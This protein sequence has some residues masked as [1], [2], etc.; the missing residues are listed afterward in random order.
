MN[1]F[2]KRLS[3]IFVSGLLILTTA[4]SCSLPGINLFNNQAK[5]NYKYGVLKF[6]PNITVDKFA[7]VNHIKT[8]DSIADN[9][10]SSFQTFNFKAYNSDRLFVLTQ[11]KGLFVS[12]NGGQFWERKYVFPINGQKQ[13]DIN[14]QIARNDQFK[15]LSY[16]IQDE[17]NFL[18]AGID[19]DSKGK[20]FKTNNGGSSFT[21]VY[22][23]FGKDI[24]VEIIKIDPQNKNIVYAVLTGGAVI[25]SNDFGNNWQKIQSF[26]ETPII[27]D[28]LNNN[29]IYALFGKSGLK[30]SN[31]GGNNW[32]DQ[33]LTK[34]S[35]NIGEN[36]NRDALI[37]NPLD[38]NETFGEFKTI[39]FIQSNLNP[40][41]IPGFLIADR[42][43]WISGDIKTQKFVKIPLPVQNE[44]NELNDIAYSPSLGQNKIYIA[45]ND[46][47]LISEDTG[48]SWNVN[49]N[50]KLN[51][52]LTIGDIQSINF[53]PNNDKIMYLTIKSLNQTKRGFF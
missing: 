38:R 43:L 3:L 44:Q 35:S 17:N 51:K 28:F 10:L 26:R 24:S 34:S 53:D 48:K 22:T 18:V 36:L 29:Q 2:F 20:I 16:T 8:G 31:D 32:T 39:K 30:I 1:I 5:V 15:A 46:K 40:A 23:E 12:P 37:F 49:D 7:F 9:A 4:Q 45:L 52:D 42:Q 14:N 50:L 33:A 41:L 13:E 19:N 27:F 21:Q 47:L 11:E 6:D 25:K